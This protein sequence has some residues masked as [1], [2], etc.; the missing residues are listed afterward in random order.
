ML[1]ASHFWAMPEAGVFVKSNLSLLSK[2]PEGGVGLAETVQMW[3]GGAGS[4]EQIWVVAGRDSWRN[5]AWLQITPSGSIK[6]PG[7]SSHTH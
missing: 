3:L 4:V 5:D 2:V 1:F 6:I 7:I